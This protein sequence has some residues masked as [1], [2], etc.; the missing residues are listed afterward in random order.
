MNIFKSHSL[1]FGRAPEPV[2]PYQ[3]AG[4]LWDDYVGSARAQMRSWRLIAFGLVGVVAIVGTDNLRIRLQATVT[5]FLVEIDRTGALLGI[6]QATGSRK[7]SDVQLAYQLGRFVTNFRSKSIDPV[8]I[9][10]NWLDAYAFASGQARQTLNDQANRNDPFADI[11]HKAVSVEIN[12]VVRLS[13]N[14]MQARWTERAYDD[15]ALTSTDR[16][17]GIL[18]LAEHPARTETELRA[19]PFGFT[20]DAI[21]FT[22]EN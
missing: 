6:D 17:V 22:K 14:S 9:K 11:G 18:T 19:N 7:L 20:V 16:Y 10:Q 2:T 4:Q 13:D 15:G 3:R 1:R 12:S 5:P 21:S 8:V